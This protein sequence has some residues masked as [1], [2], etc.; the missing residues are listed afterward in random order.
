MVG[1][2]SVVADGVD[3]RTTVSEVRIGRGYVHRN[4][5][6]GLGVGGCLNADAE[7]SDIE[8]VGEMFCRIYERNALEKV[9]IGIEG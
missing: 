7:V 9:E 1:L 3:T 2:L 5:A 4:A 6:E 8:D